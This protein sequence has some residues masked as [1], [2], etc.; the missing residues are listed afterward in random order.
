M[1]NHEQTPKFFIDKS[2]KFV[3][4]SPMRQFK[5]TVP[6]A[7]EMKQQTYLEAFNKEVMLRNAR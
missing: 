7:A 6:F 2:P 1:F 3:Q 4:M 5:R